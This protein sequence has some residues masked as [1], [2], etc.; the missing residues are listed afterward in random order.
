MVCFYLAAQAV[1]FLFPATIHF[2]LIFVSSSDYRSR[3]AQALAALGTPST[4]RPILVDLISQHSL[5]LTI[6]PTL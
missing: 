5:L 6:L 4:R 3:E 1:A 2:S